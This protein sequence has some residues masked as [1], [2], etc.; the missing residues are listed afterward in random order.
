MDFD[1]VFCRRFY[2][3]KQHRAE[4]LAHSTLIRP[5]D[6]RHYEGLVPLIKLAT[7]TH[8]NPRLVLEAYIPIRRSASKQFQ[9]TTLKVYVLRIAFADG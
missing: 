5:E 3:E 1:P 6:I 2:G 7:R 9:S 8:S 4:Y